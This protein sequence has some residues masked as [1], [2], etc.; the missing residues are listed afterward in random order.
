MSMVQEAVTFDAELIRSAYQ[1]LNRGDKLT[2]DEIVETLRFLAPM[3]QY[4]WAMDS[5]YTFFLSEVRSTANKLRE[6]QS[7]RVAYGEW[8]PSMEIKN[9][10]FLQKP[11]PVAKTPPALHGFEGLEHANGGQN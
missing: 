1:K 11:A 9:P 3:E 6:W 7:S 2:D 4:G 10:R 5:R 8:S